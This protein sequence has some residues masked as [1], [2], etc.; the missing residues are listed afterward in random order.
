VVGAAL[1]KKFG[2]RTPAIITKL[3]MRQPLVDDERYAHDII[4]DLISN[5]SEVVKTRYRF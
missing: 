3:K 2:D 4:V 1:R 5:G